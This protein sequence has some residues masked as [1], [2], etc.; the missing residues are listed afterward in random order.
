LYYL[1]PSH[2]HNCTGF[3]LNA[4]EFNSRITDFNTS[5]QNESKDIAIRMQVRTFTTGENV[6]AGDALRVSGATVLKADNT[7][8]SGI[9]GFVGFATETITL[10]NPCRV[11][12]NMVEG[13]SGL[14][15][16]DT[17]YIGVS[18]SITNTKPSSNVKVVGVADTTTSIF[19]S[20]L[21]QED[22]SFSSINLSGNLTIDTDLF[23]VDSNNDKISIGT[24]TPSSTGLLG[25]AQLTVERDSFASFQMFSHNSTAGDGSFVSLVRSRGTEGSELIVSNDDVLGSIYAIGHDGTTYRNASSISTE[26]DGTPSVSDMP[27]RMVFSVTKSGESTPTEMMRI[28]SNSYVGVGA[29]ASDSKLYVFQGN[30]TA[31]IPVLKLEQDDTS[32]PFIRYEGTATADANS[33]ISTLN[34]SGATTDHIQISLNGTKAWIAVSTID[35]T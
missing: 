18:G 16:G 30:T 2:D 26:V 23:Y 8:V 4:S 27:S 25:I 14:T 32:E 6:S 34:T 21:T 22:A 29:T 19:I 15:A 10:G 31:G 13:L 35:P 12:Y 11:A 33:S 17:Y 24:T 1:F 5:L 3:P 7:S 20:P 28:S 9:T